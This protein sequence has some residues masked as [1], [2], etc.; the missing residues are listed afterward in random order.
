[1][2]EIY[3][4]LKGTMIVHDKYQGIVCGYNETHF[5]LAVE[6]KETGKFFRVLKRDFFVEDAFKDPKY[7]YIF[8][9]ERVIVKQK[10]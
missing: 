1:M 3:E 6:T 10:G 2:E 8:E 5:I 9:D 4:E 7:R